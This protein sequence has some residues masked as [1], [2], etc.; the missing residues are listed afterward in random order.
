MRSSARCYL[1]KRNF[2][3]SQ[4]S[5]REKLPGS[6]YEIGRVG[7]TDRYGNFGKENDI[8]TS[9]QSKHIFH[10]PAPRL[11]TK[12]TELSQLHYIPPY[13]EC[14]IFSCLTNKRRSNAPTDAL[15][16][17]RRTQRVGEV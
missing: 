11:A 10:G 1:T 13:T 12:S 16:A 2:T 5:P 6:N 14:F 4:L 15:P 3:T 8:F 17:S 9:R 7:P